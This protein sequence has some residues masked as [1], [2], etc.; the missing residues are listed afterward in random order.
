MLRKS[1]MY[2]EVVDDLMTSDQGIEVKNFLR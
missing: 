1:D 2:K